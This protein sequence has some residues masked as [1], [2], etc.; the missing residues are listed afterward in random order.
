MN[1]ESSSLLSLI[2]TH[3]YLVAFPLAII[4]GPIVMVGCGFLSRLGYLDFW[5]IYFVLLFGDFVADLGWYA[6][7]RFGAHKFIRRWGKYFS[8]SENAVKK[9]EHLFDKYD[10][11]ILFTSKITMGFGFAVA[12]LVAAGMAKVPL[13]RYAVINFLGGLIWTALLLHIGYF[14]GN[15]YTAVD[16]GFRFAYLLGAL[17]LSAAALFGLGLY[18]RRKIIERR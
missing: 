3:K 16:R 15:L 17:A 14:F 18:L 9:I 5:S 4:E 13:K 12:T 7:G 11:K 6:V 10:D 1:A 8:V 2:L